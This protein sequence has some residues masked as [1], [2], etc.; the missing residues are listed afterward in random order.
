MEDRR[1]VL[2]VDG[3]VSLHVSSLPSHSGGSPEDTGVQLP[4]HPSSPSVAIS[5]LVPCLRLIV[6]VTP[7]HQLRVDTV[8]AD[9]PP[10]AAPMGLAPR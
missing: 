5:T 9:T 1:L 3:S 2:S 6:P 7:D 8:S 10:R 4:R